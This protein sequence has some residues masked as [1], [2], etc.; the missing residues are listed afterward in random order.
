M[1]GSTLCLI[2]LRIR[3]RRWD[4]THA[5]AHRVLM[6]RSKDLLVTSST[7]MLA[8]VYPLTSLSTTSSLPFASYSMCS[9]MCFSLMG[10]STSWADIVPFS[11]SAPTEEETEVG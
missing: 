2:L 9:S 4:S 5:L 7:T 3:P 6:R 11:E 10:V 8:V 1:Q